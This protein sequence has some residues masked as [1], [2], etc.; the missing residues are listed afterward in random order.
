MPTRLSAL[1]P[2]DQWLQIT[3]MDDTN[4]FTIRQIKMEGD[5]VFVVQDENGNSVMLGDLW[6]DKTAVL[7]FTRHFG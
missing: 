2:R 6:R 4:T 1:K 3:N 5:D 7:V